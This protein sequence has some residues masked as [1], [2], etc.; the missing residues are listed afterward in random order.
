[1]SKV[2]LE[3][4][5]EAW[6]FSSSQYVQATVKNV[7][8]SLAKQGAKLP[9]RANTPLSS[10]YSSKIDVTDKLEPLEA[11]NF[12][13]LIGLLRWMVELGEVD[14]CCEVSMM[15]LKRAISYLCIPS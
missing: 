15:S 8:E 13:S 9:A 7:E 3:N 6:A 10:N 11:S 5:V 12:Q 2:T 4:M 1:M 14:I